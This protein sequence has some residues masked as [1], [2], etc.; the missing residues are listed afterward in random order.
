[1]SNLPSSIL[2][3]SVGPTTDLKAQKKLF[4]TN[5]MTLKPSIRSPFSKIRSK[6]LLLG[7]L[8]MYYTSSIN[9][10]QGGEGGQKARSPTNFSSVTSANVEIVPLKLSDF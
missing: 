9:P 5:K 2:W 7:K 10:I 1:M 6:N 3:K 4:M 8:I